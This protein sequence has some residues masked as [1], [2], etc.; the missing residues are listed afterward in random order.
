[1]TK[2]ANPGRPKQTMSHLSKERIFATALKIVTNEGPKALSFRAVAKMLNVSPM[3]VKYHA[4]TKHIL[5]KNVIGEA[6]SGIAGKPVGEAPVDRIRFLLSRYCEYAIKHVHLI[7]CILSDP[8]LMTEDFD[9]MNTL[10]KSEVIALSGSDTDDIIFNLI[11]DYTHGF[12]YAAAAASPKR[13]LK[14]ETF[15]QSLDWVLKKVETES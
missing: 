15:L 7:S 14:V 5:L 12:I 10:I 6:F 9:H 1:M 2:N 4:G 3:A 8:T 11:I 13:A